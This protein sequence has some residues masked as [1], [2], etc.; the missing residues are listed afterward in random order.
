MNAKKIVAALLSI[1]CLVPVAAFLTSTV[2]VARAEAPAHV[3][4]PRV[5][6]TVTLAE[7]TVVGE[8]RRPAKKQARP[9]A[10]PVAPASRNCVVRPLEQGGPGNVRACNM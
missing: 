4:A 10:R 5:Y 3:Q 6:P 8:V 9:V 7:V 1:A 2:S